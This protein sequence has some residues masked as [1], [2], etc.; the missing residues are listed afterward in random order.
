VVVQEFHG[1][2]LAD[3][4][5]ILVEHVHY[6]LGIFDLEAHYAAQYSA[7]NVLGQVS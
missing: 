6:Q 3:S 7:G 2:L 5:V 1:H 4:T